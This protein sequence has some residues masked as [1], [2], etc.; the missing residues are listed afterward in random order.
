MVMTKRLKLHRVSSLALLQSYQAGVTLVHAVDLLEEQNWTED[1][2]VV[3]FE[4]ATKAAV[5]V[6]LSLCHLNTKRCPHGTVSQTELN[7][8][9]EGMMGDKQCSGVLEKALRLLN[10][11]A[12]IWCAEAH[13]EGYMCGKAV[14]DDPVSSDFID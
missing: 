12:L 10:A 11:P 9:P 1:T 7:M 14:Q 3:T 6:Q 8:L 5:D 2:P 4:N 13:T